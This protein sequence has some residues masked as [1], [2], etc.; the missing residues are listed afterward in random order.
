M[1]KKSWWQK[2]IDKLASANQKEYGNQTPDCC[3]S[4]K[5]S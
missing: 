2:F 1:A 3:S 4:E 5:N